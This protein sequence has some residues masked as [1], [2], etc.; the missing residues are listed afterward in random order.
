MLIQSETWLIVWY[1]Y[2]TAGAPAP[3]SA[4]RAWLIEVARVIQNIMLR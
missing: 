1:R 2:S 4:D 3:I